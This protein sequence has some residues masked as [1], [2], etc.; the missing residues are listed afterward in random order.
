[1]YD[2][3]KINEL[4]V[5]KAITGTTGQTIG[6]SID[7]KKSGLDIGNG[8]DIFLAIDIDT[9]F[10]GTTT[11]LSFDVVSTDTDPD[12]ANTAT[13]STPLT[14][15]VH[16]TG[17]VYAAIANL[18]GAGAAGNRILAIQLPRGAYKRY[19][20]LR[21]N[22]ATATPT[23]GKINAYLTTEPNG[24]TALPQAVIGA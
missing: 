8:Q 16:I 19:L 7:L 3:S 1:M 9:A 17:T 5:S 21:A 6:K 18:P 22:F 13:P 14:P 2:I 23:T 12:A 10:T 11:A 4:V 20:A 15:T 24:W